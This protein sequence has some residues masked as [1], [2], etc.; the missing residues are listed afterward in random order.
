[1]KRYLGV[2]GMGIMKIMGI[3]LGILLQKKEIMFNESGFKILVDF[4]LTK[5][6]TKKEL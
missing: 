6:N 3:Y 5:A 2:A 4:H 1:M